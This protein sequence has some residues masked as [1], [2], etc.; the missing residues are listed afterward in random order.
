MKALVVTT[1]YVN[2]YGA[3][4]QAYGMHCLMEKEGMTHEFLKQIPGDAHIFQSVFPVCAT[5]VHKLAE[6]LK[7][8]PYA[9]ALKRRLKNFEQFRK[10]HLPETRLFTSQDDVIKNADV[11]DLYI[12]GGDQMFNRSCLNRPVN[13]L[14][15]GPKEA[16][17]ISYST[18]LGAAEFTDDEMRQLCQRFSHYQTI[19][20]REGDHAKKLQ[21]LL[22]V[23]VRSDLDGSFLIDG[24]DWEKVEVFDASHYPKKYILVYEL[25]HHSHLKKAVEAVRKKYQLPVV[26][27]TADAKV[28]CQA[29]IVVRDAGPGEF[30]GLFHHASFIVTTSFHGT[31]FSVIFRKPFLSLV[32][33]NEQ[34]IPFLLQEF[35]LSDYY[36][37]KFE[38]LP[39]QEPNFTIAQK[40][41]SQ[42]RA[43]S[44]AY[45]RRFWNEE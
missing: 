21:Q 44:M 23:T 14:E 41:I 27:I 40:K 45:L 5:S 42:G 9:A 8:L 12:T 2:N 32:R 10:Q 43:E 3:V 37:A 39:E 18:S 31:C 11:Y 35:G 20:L 25:L 19:S 33:E 24:K 1:Q 17:R 4:L 34:R 28:T 29:D 7:K 6:N 36:T 16:C 13:L 22:K 30:I 15:F 38:T 26:V